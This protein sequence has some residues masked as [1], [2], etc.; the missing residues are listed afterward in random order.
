M[1]PTII[2]IV[3]AAFLV[4]ATAPASSTT[5]PCDPLVPDRTWDVIDSPLGR[6][7]VTG[8]RSS[9]AANEVV[10]A[11]NGASDDLVATF[12]RPS[13]PLAFCVVP[14]RQDIRAPGISQTSPVAGA[15]LVTTNAAVIAADSGDPGRV[16]IHEAAHLLAGDR[17]RNE[18]ER[19][20]PEWISEGIAEIASR[21]I[22]DRAKRTEALVAAGDLPGLSQLEAESLSTLDATASDRFYVA[23]AAFTDELIREAGW[24][25][26]WRM[27]KISGKFP[28]D[29]ELRLRAHLAE[30]GGI[31][32]GAA[33]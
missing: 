27:L 7:F 4:L 5:S 6:V 22:G 19:P 25:G 13:H 11:L 29:L 33:A 2:G 20:L 8:Q 10:K 18:G 1:R 26:V 15:A 24:D 32:T 23:S 16:A 12:G 28:A 21:S 3:V 30:V 31:A 17:A 14:T 9:G